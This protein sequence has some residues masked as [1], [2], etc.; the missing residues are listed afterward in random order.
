MKQFN[1]TAQVY[2][3]CGKNIGQSL[4]MNEVIFSDNE[5][6]AKKKFEF[7]LLVDDIIVQ[8]ILS[9]EEIVQDAR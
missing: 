4:L 8:K 5:H 3:M 6:N 1:V 2:D 7:D 9:V